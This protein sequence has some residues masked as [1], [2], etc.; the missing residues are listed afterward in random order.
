MGMF[1]F[2]KS[3]KPSAMGM[4]MEFFTNPGK[5]KAALMTQLYPALEEKLKNYID[6]VDL[7]DNEA[8]SAIIVFKNKETGKL[9]YCLAS[10]SEDDQIVRQ[11]EVD[12]VE[13]KLESMVGKL[14]LGQ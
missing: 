4:A 9:D 1:D 6:S 3:G 10:F 7:N 8:Q 13:A 12:N 2:M 5:L 14:K 11:I